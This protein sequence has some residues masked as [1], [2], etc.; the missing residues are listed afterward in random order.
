MLEDEVKR[1]VFQMG[2]D[3]A[4]GPDGFSPSFIQE[5]WPLVGSSVVEFV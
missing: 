3:K 4:P 2:P 1:A 5:F